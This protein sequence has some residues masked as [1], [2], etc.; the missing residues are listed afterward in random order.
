MSTA[1]ADLIAVALREL[2]AG[3]LDHWTRVSLRGT[4]RA[5]F[6]YCG[7]D[8]VAIER[9]LTVFDH[10]G[11]LLRGR[12]LTTILLGR[13]ATAR[14]ARHARRSF[15]VYGVPGDVESVPVATKAA[16]AAGAPILAYVDARGA[17][18]PSEKALHAA[19]NGRPGEMLLVWARREPAERARPALDAAGFR[20]VTEIELA[21]DGQAAQI[22][23]GTSSGKSLTAFKDAVWAAA[24]A[25]G[26][27]LR[28]PQ[29]PD[30][31]LLDPTPQPQPAALREALLARL[32]AA[33][34]ATVAELRQYAATDTIY[35]PTD[36]TEVLAALV[37]AGVVIREPA[38]GRLGGDV[39]I[40]PA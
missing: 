39:L 5:T 12:H 30:A 15:A 33:G 8:E 29:D 13:D 23:F 22:A 17:A 25:A 40:R 14:A 3:Q 1:S 37:E 31:P 2:L 18:L 32:A 24:A 19:R 36:A 6:V 21:T 35:R 26:V 28:D 38:E 10:Y 4:R 16:M 11:D 34:P 9:A 7:E 20:L 27:R